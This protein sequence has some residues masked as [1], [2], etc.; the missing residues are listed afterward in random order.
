MER[1][2][3]AGHQGSGESAYKCHSEGAHGLL[4]QLLG[5]TAGQ[6][7]L[8]H[9]NDL[10]QR[11]DRLTLPVASAARWLLHTVRRSKSRPLSTNRFAEN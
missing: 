1:R 7:S 3:V 8:G 4:R 2:D 10:D 6:D 5:D 9:G 11:S